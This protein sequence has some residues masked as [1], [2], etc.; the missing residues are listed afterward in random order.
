[1]GPLAHRYTSPVSRARCA[2]AIGDRS[3]VAD[4]KPKFASTTELAALIARSLLQ[5]GRRLFPQICRAFARLFSVSI[6]LLRTVA[7]HQSLVYLSGATFTVPIEH[8][9]L[10]NHIPTHPEPF[11]LQSL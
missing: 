3:F 5:K 10:V 1:M 7:D 2:R 4:H 6:S 9:T 11:E 8:R